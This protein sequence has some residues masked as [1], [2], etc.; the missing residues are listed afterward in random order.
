M[1][2]LESFSDILASGSSRSLVSEVLLALGIGANEIHAM[3]KK[4]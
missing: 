1:L 4:D 2:A 3:Q